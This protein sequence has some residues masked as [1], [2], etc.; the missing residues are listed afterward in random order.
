MLTN[1]QDSYAC[2]FNLK[3][4][5]PGGLFQSMFKAVRIENEDQ[6]LHV[7][8]YIHLN[9]SSSFLV[10]TENLVSYPWSSLIGYLKPEQIIWKFLNC[11]PILE[12]ANGEKKY[13]QFVFDRADYQRKLAKIK[14]LVLENP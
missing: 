6:F 8:R 10:K 12:L 4:K 3:H 1:L 14:H 5:R 11:Q 13:S 7:S 9:P 2:Y